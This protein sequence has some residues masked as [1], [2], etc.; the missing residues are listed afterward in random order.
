MK[1]RIKERDRVRVRKGR[2]ARLDNS[3]GGSV[4]PMETLARNDKHCVKYIQRCQV[5]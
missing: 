4:M 5:R 2:D 3:E 1:S